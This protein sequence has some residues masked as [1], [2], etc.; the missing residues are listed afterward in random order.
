LL[1]KKYSFLEVYEKNYLKQTYEY[2]SNKSLP[3][4]EKEYKFSKSFNSKKIIN[5]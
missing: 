4:K 5:I 1:V 2:L 3:K